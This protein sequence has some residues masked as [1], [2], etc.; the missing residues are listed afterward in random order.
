MRPCITARFRC[1]SAPFVIGGCRLAGRRPILAGLLFGLAAVKPQFGLLIPI[2]LVSARQWRTVIAAATT[3]G[4][5]AIA[6]GMAFGWATWGR[7]PSAMTG[8]SQ[9]MARQ[10]WRDGLSP[11]VTSGLR[12]LGAGPVVVD[13]GQLAASVGAAVAIWVCFRRG[14][15]PLGTAALLVGAVLVTPYAWFYDLPMVSYAVL[16]VVIDRHQSREPFGTAELAVLILSV[17]LP[18]L[19]VAGPPWVPWGIAVLPLLFMAILR[20]IAATTIAPEPRPA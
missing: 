13:A 4:L 2:A 11:S 18:L 5:T 15:S 12:L 9:L 14:F 8:L 6:S 7:L 19:I 3:V 20:R 1:W 10:T 17:A 16:V